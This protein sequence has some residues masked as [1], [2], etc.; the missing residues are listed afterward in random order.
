MDG[1]GR[2]P[3]DEAIVRA[4][5]GIGQALGL[6]LV[7]EGIETIVQVARLQ[8]LGCTLGQGYYFAPPGPPAAIE[9]LLFPQ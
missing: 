6:Q 7:A 4:V 3:D 5:I 1:L 2:D 8:E 9:Q